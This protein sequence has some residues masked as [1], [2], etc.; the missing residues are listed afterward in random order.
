MNAGISAHFSATINKLARWVVEIR[1]H[2]RR[3]LQPERRVSGG[4]QSILRRNVF[5]ECFI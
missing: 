2:S 5:Q 3:K 4:C 1:A